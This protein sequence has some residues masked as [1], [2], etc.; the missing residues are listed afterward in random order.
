MKIFQNTVSMLKKKKFTWRTPTLFY[1]Y[2]DERQ[3]CLSN[4]VTGEVIPS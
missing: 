2:Y 1:L 4:N 3:L